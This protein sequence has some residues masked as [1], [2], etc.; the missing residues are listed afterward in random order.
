[1]SMD[2]VFVLFC[3]V[4]VL[5]GFFGLMLQSMIIL[6]VLFLLLKHSASDISTC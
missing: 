3:F 2:V 6:F 1:M 5:G 4:F